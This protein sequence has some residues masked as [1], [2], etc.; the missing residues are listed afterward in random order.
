MPI[1]QCLDMGVKMTNA[2]TKHRKSVLSSLCGF[3]GS[4]TEDHRKPVKTVICHVSA[5]RCL[6]CTDFK[7]ILWSLSMLAVPVH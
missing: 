6:D 3:Y 5:Q 4:V 7:M 2:T 1:R